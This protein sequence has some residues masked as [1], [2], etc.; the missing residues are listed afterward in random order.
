MHGVGASGKKVRISF[1]Y[2]KIDLYMVTKMKESKFTQMSSK[3]QVVIPKEIRKEMQLE[4]GTPFAVIAKHDTIL[5]KKV[6]IGKVKSWDEATK[7]FRTA[8]KKSKFTKHD[9]HKLIED[10]RRSKHA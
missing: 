9:L 1:K 6:E 3:G 10:V 4:E 5:L 8:A 7:P 2:R